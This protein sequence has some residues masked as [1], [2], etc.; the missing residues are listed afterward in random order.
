MLARTRKHETA[1]PAG[2]DNF[3]DSLDS[4]LSLNALDYYRPFVGACPDNDDNNDDNGNPRTRW[5]TRGRLADCTPRLRCAF[6]SL[7]DTLALLT[8]E[9]LLTFDATQAHFVG[10]LPNSTQERL[11]RH[12]RI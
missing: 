3:D 4:L 10:Q 6:V 11:T 7:L 8:L 12:S 1:V 9:A 2:N 5:A